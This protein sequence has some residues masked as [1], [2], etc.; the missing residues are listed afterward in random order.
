MTK[1][2][3]GIGKLDPITARVA[4][5]LAELGLAF[6]GAVHQDP[7][8]FPSDLTAT[9]MLELGELHSYWSAQF[10]RT[11]TVHGVVVAQK[12]SLKFELTRLRA[13][14][15]SAEQA[16]TIEERR[17]QLEAEHARVDAAD[18]MLS[19]LVDG[20]KRYVDACSREI[21][22]RQIEVQLSR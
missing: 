16:S 14:L 9:S 15:P 1:L 22:R 4:D 21:T 17:R 11:T 18:A 5:T 13:V 2:L 12:R 20:Q 7:V 3:A 19:G 10:A 8:E 6:P